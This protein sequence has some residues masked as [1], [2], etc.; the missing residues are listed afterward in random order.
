MLGGFEQDVGRRTTV[1]MFWGDF[2][3]SIP[4]FDEAQ[5]AMP[6]A[7]RAVAVQAPSTKRDIESH[8]EALR[9]PAW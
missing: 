7:E 2:G 8:F 4:R 3:Q 5:A 9:A 6:L 1:Q